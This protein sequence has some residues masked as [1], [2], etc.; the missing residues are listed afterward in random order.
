MFVLKVRPFADTGKS[1]KFTINHY[2]MPGDSLNININNKGVAANTFQAIVIGSGISGGWA[3]KE[4]CE[5]GVKT[6]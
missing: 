2:V 5:H 4:L 3:A 1:S 6:L